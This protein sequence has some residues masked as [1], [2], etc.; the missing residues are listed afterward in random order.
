MILQRFKV[1][2]KEKFAVKFRKSYYDFDRNPKKNKRVAKF[3]RKT[4]RKF[5]QIKCM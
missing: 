1:F 3:Y 5:E 4:A 2:F